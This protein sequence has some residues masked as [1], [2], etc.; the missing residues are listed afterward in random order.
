MT[1]TARSVLGSDHD[2]IATVFCIVFTFVG[3]GDYV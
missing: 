3:V 2:A 1:W